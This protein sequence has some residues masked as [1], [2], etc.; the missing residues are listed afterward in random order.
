[1]RY[2]K[3]DDNLKWITEISFTKERN[4]FWV[5]VKASQ[6]SASA[7]S[8]TQEIKKPIIAIR[9]LSRFGGG[10]D[11]DLPINP[12]P[13]YL[14]DC[15]TGHKLA[16]ALIN[17]DSVNRLPVVYISA[18]YTGHRV[19]PDRLARKLSGMAHVIVEPS[20]EFSI[21][22]RNSV[23]S[24]NV[25]GGAVGIYWPGGSGVSLFRRG[26]SEI[27]T[28][29]NDIY[30]KICSALLTLSPARKCSWDE[31]GHIKNRNAIRKLKKDGDSANDLVSLYECELTEK[32][33][34][35]KELNQEIERLGA[36]IRH[37]ES[38]TP[39]QGG[40]ILNKGDEDDYFDNE[41]I[42]IVMNAL[43]DYL[44]K[45]THENSRRAHILKS[46]LENNQIESTNDENIRTVKSALKGYR[47]MSKKIRDALEGLGFSMTSEGKH[48]KI[49]YQDDERYSYILPKS[50]S[51][52]RGGLNAGADITN[53]V[54]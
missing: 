48:W 4:D 49:I 27:K 50:G 12:E 38:R 1:M 21:K 31:V 41:I 44:E 29:E 19:I 53:L 2:K 43:S 28:F 7:A 16:K 23:H 26:S 8:S 30:E 13:I 35:I 14:K 18:S 54:F 17:G 40:L 33:S 32:E 52:Y 42:C 24:R 22:I 36:K 20:R 25:Y 34:I 10:L 3:G 11:G 47:E 37:L 46:I 6:E 15:E 39:V 45:S 5:S 9:L 51:D